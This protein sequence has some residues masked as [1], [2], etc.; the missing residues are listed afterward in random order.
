MTTTRRVRNGTGLIQRDLRTWCTR[1]A[2]A[3]CVN[4]C[5][6][7]WWC[8]LS[9]FTKLVV[10]QHRFLP[11]VNRRLGLCSVLV[12]HDPRVA[13]VRTP[14]RWIGGVDRFVLLRCAPMR[15]P[16]VSHSSNA[17]PH[18]RLP[19][20]LN[21]APSRKGCVVNGQMIAATNK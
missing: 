10:L 18:A 1:F 5:K 12:R 16:T 6:Y 2:C 17:Q 15:T 13:L 9:R 11:S 21:S 8:S 3:L 4:S 7:W 20:P 19:P 14:R